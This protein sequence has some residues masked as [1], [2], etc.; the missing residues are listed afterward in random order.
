MRADL[1]SDSPEPTPQVN[2]NDATLSSFCDRKYTFSVNNIPSKRRKPWYENVG[3]IVQDPA[4][5]SVLVF[6]IIAIALDLS[7][8]REDY[9]S[10][11]ECVTMIAIVAVI[12]LLET[13]TWA[14]QKVHYQCIG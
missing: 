5:I 2:V 1:E 3:V 9:P 14:L 12:I 7:G 8:A 4:L 13:F 10:R 11:Y 6:S